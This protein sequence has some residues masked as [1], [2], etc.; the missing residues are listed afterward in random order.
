MA[1]TN[2]AGNTGKMTVQQNCD[3][4][5]AM[6][7]LAQSARRAVLLGAVPPANRFPL[8]ARVKTVGR[9]GRSTCSCKT[10]PVAPA[11][12]SS[13]SPA[14]AVETGAMARRWL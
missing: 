5:Q 8:A 4:L 2:V 9:S 12:P 1:G 11:P 6:T 13:T 10:T 14:L 7:E 3:N